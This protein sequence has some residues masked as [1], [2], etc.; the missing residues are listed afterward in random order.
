[1]KKI[2]RP[3]NIMASIRGR[4]GLTQEQFAIQ[5]GI[6]K[7]KVKLV[8][9]NRR[10]IPSDLLIK[11]AAMEIEL[12]A[13]PKMNEKE[14]PRA[15]KE[16]YNNNSAGHA[17]EIKLR[18]SYCHQK[19]LL[20]SKN[21]L[22]M[23]H[24][25][26]LLADRLRNLDVMEKALRNADEQRLNSIHNTRAQ[27]LKKITKCGP[28]AQAAIRHKIALLRAEV[29]L[30]KSIQPSYVHKNDKLILS[31]LKQTEMDY[32]VSM[33]SSRADCQ[34][35]IDIANDDNDS[36]AY[37]KTGLLRQIQNAS[38]T[39]VSIEADLA[40]VT[41]ELTALQTVLDNLPDG[42]I[43]DETRVK[44]KKAEY[45]KFLLEERKANYGSVA[46]LNKQYD[47]ACVE[48]SIAETGAFILALT[49]R[50]NELP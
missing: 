39:S 26:E 5:L 28:L 42:E 3:G 15:L 38:S 20:L 29:V 21:L 45:R 10:N 47:I 24:Q 36:L 34:A 13:V 27:L 31:P 25:Y 18:E 22:K 41:A 44:F 1:M 8:E 49:A 32:S 23:Q 37:R 9:T 4:M 48:Q 50:M 43:K 30:S 7:S 33:I 11:L 17:L 16:L 46:L 19:S 14:L 6:S 35:M 40:S 12:V 2:N